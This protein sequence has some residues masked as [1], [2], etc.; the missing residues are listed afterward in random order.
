[1]TRIQR[2]LNFFILIN[3]G[4]GTVA[5][6]LSVII[7][8]G[9]TAVWFATA[10]FVSDQVESQIQRPI[11]P[12]AEGLALG[13]TWLTATAI[14]FK[15]WHK[16]EEFEILDSPTS[17]ASID[18]RRER[19]EA[20]Q[21]ALNQACQGEEFEDWLEQR[22]EERQQAFEIWPEQATVA[23]ACQNCQHYHGETYNDT[24]LVCAMH[25]YGCKSEI[26]PDWES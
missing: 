14:A 24:L 5:C 16:S 4:S 12:A 8:A 11:L 26:C 1:M 25:P 19:C 2:L 10:P 23:T 3:E 13:L 20:Q 17:T 22:Y 9:T 18:W 6:L 15:K 21:R 7:F